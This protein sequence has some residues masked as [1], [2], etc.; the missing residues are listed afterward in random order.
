M[1]KISI[2]SWAYNMGYYDSNPIPLDVVAAKLSELKFDGIELC[3]HRPH[4][5]PL[6]YSTKKDR[7]DLVGTLEG[8]GLEISAYL[9]DLSNFPILSGYESIRK[10]YLKSFDI[11]LQFCVDCGIER[12]RVD[13]GGVWFRVKVVDAPEYRPK[14]DAAW[15]RVVTM[16]RECAKRASNHGVTVLWEFEPTSL[17]NKP[18]EILKLLNEIDHPNFKALFETCHAQLVAVMAALQTPPIEVLK[19]GVAEFARLLKGKIGHVHLID[20]DNTMHHG[21]Y[22]KKTMFGEGVLDFDEI[23]PALKDGEYSSEWWT[24]DLCF[25]PAAWE[26]TEKAKRFVDRLVQKYG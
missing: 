11:N 21:V 18:S 24:I 17:F 10:G 8:Y 5:H 13:E 12:I 20:S 16:W 14:Y 4:A 19:G 15:S 6:D 3:G 9:P 1:K 26:P 7:E 22:S 25:L 23:M 2:G